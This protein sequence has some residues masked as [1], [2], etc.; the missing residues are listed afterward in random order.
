MGLPGGIDLITCYTMSRC[1]TT[2][3]GARFNSVTERPLTEL[4]LI[5]TTA[6]RLVKQNIAILSDGA[7]KRTLAANQKE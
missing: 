6:P 3:L 5:P 1:S 4:L 7:Y 2:E